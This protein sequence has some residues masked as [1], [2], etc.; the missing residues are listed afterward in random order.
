MK[1][2]P[3]Q[4]N[5][6]SFK[7]SVV[8]LIVL[9][10]AGCVKTLTLKNGYQKAPVSAKVFKNRVYFDPVILKQMDTASIYE[11]FETDYY[12]GEEKQ[13]N[14]LARLNYKDPNTIY[15][16]YRFYSSGQF[17]LFFL[18]RNIPD[19]TTE[20]FDPNYAG[21]RGVLY[22]KKRVKGD[23]FTQVGPQSWQLGVQTYNF[24]FNGDTLIVELPNK[25][26]E[27]Y[28]KRMMDPHLLK[29]SAGW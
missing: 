7:K 2:M 18:D 5:M 17:N 24:D 13:P 27:Y 22:R 4:P 20:M 11:Q 14:V 23:L 28:I 26:K 16:V 15:G 25:T 10:L 9:V 8:L 6:T 21:W 3:L 12:E 29:H 1:P 19:L